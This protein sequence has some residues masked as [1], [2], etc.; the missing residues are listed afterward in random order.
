MQRLPPNPSLGWQQVNFSS[1]IPVS[2]NTVY[3]ASYFAP[4]GHYSENVSYL[5]KAGIDSPPLHALADGVSGA[6][7]VYV[8]SSKG[9]FPTTGWEST[10]YWVDVVYAASAPATPQLTVG[11]TSLSFGSVAVNSSATQSLTLT[12]SGAAA[13]TVNSAAISGTGF[14]IVGGTSSA[15]LNPNQTT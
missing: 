5:A 1:P 11:A 8:Y 15:M 4:Q 10:Y 2:A 9:G 3:V 12:S 14:T 6:D 7:G 13:V